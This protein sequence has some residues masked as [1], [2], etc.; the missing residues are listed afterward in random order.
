MMMARM[1]AIFFVSGVS[2]CVHAQTELKFEAAATAKGKLV[3]TERHL[4]QFD[5]AQKP[6]QA[7]T[8][9]LD[10]SSKVIATM[11]TEFKNSLS[12]P[13]HVFKNLRSEHVHGIRYTDSHTVLFYSDKGAAEKSKNFPK[14]FD[15]KF[16]AVGGQG[17]F[18]YLR[19]NY[20]EVQKRKKIPLKF[21]IPGRLDVYDFE[22][23]LKS[24]KDGVAHI[25]L[26]IKNW[27]LRILAP[28]L[29][30]FYDIQKKRL[31]SYQGLSNITDERGQTQVVNITY[32]YAD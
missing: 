10:S 2:L 17:L 9:Y 15:K 1:L 16:L 12:A 6:I 27:I 8:D 22:L 18:Y 4:V 11:E 20:S 30:V 19:E 14:E 24:E 3:Y 31:V 23:E 28:K 21:L 7:K 32:T 25:E 26:H 5:A 13:D 29:D